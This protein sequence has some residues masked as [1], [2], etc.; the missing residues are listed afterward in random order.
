M[1]TGYDTA[2]LVPERICAQCGQ[3]EPRHLPMCPVLGA[4]AA[5]APPEPEG[6]GV[7]S[8]SV[9]PETLEAEQDME[10]KLGEAVLPVD[11]L[12]VLGLDLSPT[13][14]G[15]A[16]AVS[17]P[18]GGAPFTFRIRSAKRDWDRLD[19]QVTRIGQAIREYD[20][21]LIMIEGPAYH[22]TGAWFHEN[23]GLWWAVTHRVWKS[24]RPFAVVPPAVLKKFATGK[25]TADK[26]AMCVA[27]ATRFGL[28]EIGPD[29]AD[30]LWLAAAGCQHYGMPLVK[31]PAGQAAAL[32]N[33]TRP[34]KGPPRPVVD[35]PVSL[36]WD[37]PQPVPA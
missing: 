21:D 19:S 24:G 1:T 17:G 31:M 12:T 8:P 5:Q 14:T 6:P 33:V 2:G 37:R 25:G 36:D 4:P 34:K 22:A 16:R 18:L 13:S 3:V 30:A 23:A 29:E 28:T 10:H 35:W 26:T 7:A 32:E 11:T 9:S 27:A 20:P 15:G